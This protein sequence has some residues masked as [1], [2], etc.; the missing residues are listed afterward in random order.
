MAT[1][2]GLY[3]EM[4]TAKFERHLAGAMLAAAVNGYLEPG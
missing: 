2:P 3:S 4:D 1:I